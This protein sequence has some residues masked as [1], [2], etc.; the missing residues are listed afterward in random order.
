MFSGSSIRQQCS[1]ILIKIICF[2]C[3]ILRERK[4]LGIDGL[5]QH[6][7]NCLPRVGTYIPDIQ[8]GPRIPE[9]NTKDFY[10]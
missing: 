5:A 1:R 7:P 10:V 2:G 4:N 3:H 6:N 9:G 8:R